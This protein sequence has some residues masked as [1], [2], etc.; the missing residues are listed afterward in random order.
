MDT[1]FIKSAARPE[2]FPPPSHPEIA[3]LGRSNA[4]KS[5]L[6][7]T[8]VNRKNLA[9]AGSTPGVTQLVNF[10]E[11]KTTHQFILVDLP[12]YGFRQAPKEVSQNW[13]KTI[14]AYLARPSIAHFVFLADARRKL[15][16]D[17]LYVLDMINAH[18]QP[19]YLLTKTDKLNQNER[20]TAL[21]KISSQL[22]DLKITPEYLAAVSSLNRL[23]IDDLRKFLF[24]LKS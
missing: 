2:H 13:E 17:D 1:Q 23:G 4:G 10:F 6:L 5:S 21:K 3:F 14:A 15:D 19:C 8:L 18:K 12:G 24:S 7:N 16:D 9:R 22:E 20:A 11:L